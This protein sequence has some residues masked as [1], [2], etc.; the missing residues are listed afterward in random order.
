MQM[1][2]ECDEPR[3]SGDPP[4]PFQ[5]EE[6]CTLDWAVEREVRWKHVLWAAKEGGKEEGEIL[7]EERDINVLVVKEGVKLIL[8][9]PPSE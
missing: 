2:E 8:R 4:D 3:E 6:F 5:G 7:V 1:S 9:K